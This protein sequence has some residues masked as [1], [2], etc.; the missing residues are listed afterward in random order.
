MSVDIDLISKHGAPQLFESIVC[1]YQ[2]YLNGV[3]K[4]K[5]QMNLF[6]KEKWRLPR[7]QCS[8]LM[9]QVIYVSAQDLSH[10]ISNF[11][12]Y[13]VRCMEKCLAPKCQQIMKTHQRWTLN[14]KNLHVSNWKPNVLMTRDTIGVQRPLSLCLPAVCSQSL[15]LYRV[16]SWQHLKSRASACSRLVPGCL[17]A[18]TDVPSDTGDVD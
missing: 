8:P 2:K 7:A 16:G 3:E 17:L 9:Y 10:D 13:H 4:N 15:L 12:Q 14:C 6:Q 18:H 5:I 11:Q 1:K